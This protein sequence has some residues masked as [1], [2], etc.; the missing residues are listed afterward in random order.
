MQH[1][2]KWAIFKCIRLYL[3]QEGLFAS[4]TYNE[5]HF[6]STKKNVESIKLQLK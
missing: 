1:D 2:S 4:E 3:K 6:Q 5:S